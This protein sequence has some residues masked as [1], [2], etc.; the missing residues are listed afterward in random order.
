MADS[1]VR[2]LLDTQWKCHELSIG[3]R[4]S[5]ENSVLEILIQG[6]L[7]WRKVFKTMFT[8]KEHQAV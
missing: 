8:I 3:V 1:N 2:C 5:G 6:L 7:S 4:S